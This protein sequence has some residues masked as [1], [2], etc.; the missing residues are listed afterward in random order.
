MDARSGLPARGSCSHKPVVLFLIADCRLVTVS[1]KNSCVFGQDIETGT[2][3][4]KQSLPVACGQVRTADGSFEKRVAADQDMTVFDIIGAAPLCVTGRE[5]RLQGDTRNSDL[6]I[7]LKIEIRRYRA[8]TAY[9]RGLI[10][11]GILTEALFMNAG[12]NRGVCVGLEGLQ[13]QNMVEMGMGQ[14]DRLH[15]QA[16]LFQFLIEPV[17][18]IRRVKNNG[19]IA[20]FP[21]KEVKIGLYHADYKTVYLDNAIRIRHYIFLLRMVNP[22]TVSGESGNSESL[23]CKRIIH[24]D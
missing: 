11:R 18:Q 20:A 15:R 17:A 13:P 4:L 16:A 5:D 2:D 21:V 12:I 9:A 7:I 14:K 24:G 10:E 1:G 3:G 23:S 8:G 19:L 6:L 22:E